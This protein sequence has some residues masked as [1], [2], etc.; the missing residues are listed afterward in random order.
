MLDLDGR[1]VDVRIVEN[2]R[3]SRMTLRLVPAT[4]K[5]ESLRLTVPPGIADHE[6][7]AFLQRHKNWA[8]ARLARLPQAQEICDGATIQLRGVPHTIRHSGERRGVVSVGMEEAGPVIRVH[9][10]PQFLKRRVVDFLKRQ[11]RQDLTRAVTLHAKVLGVEPKSITIRDT[12]SRWGSCSSSGA[13][14]FS[15]RIVLAPPEVLDYLAAH[16]VAHLKEM[17]HSPRFWAHVK[18]LCPHMDRHRQWLRTH[19]QKLHA[20]VG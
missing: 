1:M 6:V 19:G 4:I 8:A 18:K 20:V 10:D 3:T 13:L 14:N 5:Q 12:T 17:N 9:G 11:A 16:E 2:A 15:W 7:D